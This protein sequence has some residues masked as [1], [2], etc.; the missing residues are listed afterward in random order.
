MVNSS[1]RLLFA[2][3]FR[4]KSTTNTNAV[5]AMAPSGIPIPN[6]RAVSLFL[7]ELDVGSVQPAARVVVDEPR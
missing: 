7:L 3:L 5:I 1:T 6:P 4:H 2:E